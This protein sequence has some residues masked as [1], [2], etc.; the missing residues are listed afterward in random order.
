MQERKKITQEFLTGERALFKS[1]GLDIYD[2]IFDDGGKGEWT[3]VLDSSG[4]PT[5]YIVEFV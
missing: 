5:T 4:E 2:T 1:D 3:I